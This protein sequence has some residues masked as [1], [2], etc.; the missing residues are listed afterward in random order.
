MKYPT[1]TNKLTIFDILQAIYTQETPQCT[2]VASSDV[3]DILILRIIN[4]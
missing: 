4:T 2:E 1:T 3:N